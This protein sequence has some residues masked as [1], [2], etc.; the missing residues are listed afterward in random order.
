ML[1]YNFVYQIMY[2]YKLRMNIYIH[3]LEATILIID[4]NGSLIL[5][6]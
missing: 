2:K 1:M 6:N 3:I 5:M 4:N